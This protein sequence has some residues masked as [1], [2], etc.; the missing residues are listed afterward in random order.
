MKEASKIVI[1]SLAML[2]LG[3]AFSIPTLAQD[4]PCAA[5]AKRLCQQVEPGNRQAIAQCLREHVDDLSEACRDRI[6]AAKA[7]GGATRGALREACA[8]DVQTFCQGIEPG[9]GAI[10]QCLK[11]H[12]D[13]LS[14]D[15]KAAIVQMRSEKQ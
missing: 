13:E 11:E 2:V 7:Q 9:G 14:A 12:R 15:C 10:G 1:I 5:D 6:Q 3:A 8:S 4:R